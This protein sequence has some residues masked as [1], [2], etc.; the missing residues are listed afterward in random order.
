MNR[1]AA[2]SF[3]IPALTAATTGGPTP[4]STQDNTAMQMRRA[5]LADVEVEYQG[6]RSR[7]AGHPGACRRLR[8][9]VRAVDGR[10]RP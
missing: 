6:A 5:N 10:A 9:L 2:L 1:Y 4:P 8:R 3:L 7:R